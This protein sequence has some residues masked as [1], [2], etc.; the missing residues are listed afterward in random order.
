MRRPRAPTFRRISWLAQFSLAVV[1][2]F[3]RHDGLQ[4]ASHIAFTALISIFP[5]FVGILST[6]AYLAGPETMR[7]FMQIPFDLFPMKVADTLSTVVEEV[8]ESRKG[9]LL[10]ASVVLTLWTLSSSIEA[11]RLALDEAAGARSS[12]PWWMRRAQSIGFAAAGAV[13]V[14]VTATALYAVP[15]LEHGLT[16]NVAGGN[17]SDPWATGRHVTHGCVTWLV[18]CALYRWL[19]QQRPAWKHVLLS[20]AFVT[21]V[22]A[23]ATWLFTIYMEEVANYS[24]V[25][26]SLSGIIA[27]LAFFYILA[28]TFV[29][30]AEAIAQIKARESDGTQ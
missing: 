7:D 13:I 6:T 9:G 28:V 12:R 27:M 18:V 26:G 15:F 3:L 10:G 2:G 5:F 4:S 22:W 20:G 29:L 11:L 30:G 25:Y 1:R 24:L 17:G 8:L 14:L 21:G 16:S 19:P 23:A